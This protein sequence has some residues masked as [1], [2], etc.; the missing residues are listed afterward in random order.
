MKS[1]K[2]HLLNEMYSW[3]TPQDY[4]EELEQ[5]MSDHKDSLEEHKKAN[6]FHKEKKEGFQSDK[7][8]DWIHPMDIDPD[9]APDATQQFHSNNNGINGKSYGG[10]D[11][12]DFN[13]MKS[14]MQDAHDSMNKGQ[15][16]YHGFMEDH[17][18]NQMDHHENELN[19]ATKKHKEHCQKY[20][21]DN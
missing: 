5:N 20:G 19:I 7:S 17:H 15:A 6:A 9:D 10:M 2:Q 8:Q 4:K 12:F 13:K 14:H 18:K 16:V 21:L 11:K 1:F 3:E